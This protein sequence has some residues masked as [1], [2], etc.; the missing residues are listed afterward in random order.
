MLTMGTV[1]HIH[2]ICTGKQQAEISKQAV[3]NQQ[4]SC[5]SLLATMLALHWP[6]VAHVYRTRTY[7]ATWHNR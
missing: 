3:G 7:L 1:A 2:I 6:A 4:A 5:E